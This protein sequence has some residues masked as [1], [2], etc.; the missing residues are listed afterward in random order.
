MQI[1]KVT[2]ENEQP[3]VRSTSLTEIEARLNEVIA[4]YEVCYPGL[5][6]YSGE[7]IHWRVF[8]EAKKYV[9][10]YHLKHGALPGLD[11][12]ASLLNAPVGQTSSHTVRKYFSSWALFPKQRH[13][14]PD[15]LPEVWS[16]ST[17][18]FELDEG[19][20]KTANFL[21][22]N[23]FAKLTNEVDPIIL[24]L[25]RKVKDG[26]IN[27]SV[28]DY[29]RIQHSMAQSFRSE[30]EN[31]QGWMYVG[32]SPLVIFLESLP[33]TGHLQVDKY[34]ATALKRA[35]RNERRLS[36]LTTLAEL[37]PDSN[38]SV[39]SRRAS[40]LRA[41]AE[42]IFLLGRN[43]VGRCGYSEDILN[44]L[45]EVVISAMGSSDQFE[46]MSDALAAMRVAH[47]DANGAFGKL[48]HTTEPPKGEAAECPASKKLT[49][50]LGAQGG[51]ST[52][53]AET[54]RKGQP[55]TTV[56]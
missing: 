13:A 43:S 54:P 48:L 30:L 22:S 27:I 45:S 53:P 47:T 34:L 38:S 50:S 36:A 17:E 3:E 28:E 20:W 10:D 15:D 19:L 6:N 31:A 1:Q 7:W 35:R 12:E 9:L 46:D 21:L 37:L 33:P 56:H 23:A 29:S 51:R 8:R 39:F 14:N 49:G 52:W 41:I 42:A 44:P 18:Q 24:K 5:D 4:S 32:L 55:A 16:K 40:G 2:S 26:T 25:D 11:P